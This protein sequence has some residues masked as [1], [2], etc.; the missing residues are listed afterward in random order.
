MNCNSTRVDVWLIYKCSKCDTTLKLAIDKGVNPHDIASELFDQFTNNDVKLAW[1]YAFN[2]NFL[3]KNDCVVQYTGAMYCIEGLELHNEPQDELQNKPRKWDKH[4]IVHIKSEYV[5]DLKLS[6]LLAS[7]FGISVSKLR[8]I[9]ND[10]LIT[11][12]PSCDIM[13]YRIKADITLSIKPLHDV[14]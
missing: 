9:V 11:A 2:R 3:K 13:K 5:F 4:L 14:I 6:T 8:N 7:V 10:G 12:N 1:D